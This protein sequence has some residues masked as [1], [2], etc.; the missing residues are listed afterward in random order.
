[1]SKEK[2]GTKVTHFIFGELRR[3]KVEPKIEEEAKTEEG[4]RRRCACEY[5]TFGYGSSAE[6]YK[7]CAFH[8]K[9]GIRIGDRVDPRDA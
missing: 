6:Y 2:I 8:Y 1:M 3:K 9:K 5:Y 4:R 7:V